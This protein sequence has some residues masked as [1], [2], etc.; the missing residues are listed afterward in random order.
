[1]YQVAVL[2]KAAH[3]PTLKVSLPCSNR[4]SP[5]QPFAVTPQAD[6]PP[7]PASAPLSL[8]SLIP[9]IHARLHAQ[10]IPYYAT[11]MSL[12]TTTLSLPKIH[13][14]ILPTP[15]SLPFAPPPPCKPRRQIPTK[16]D[17]NILPHTITD[18]AYASKMRNKQ[19]KKIKNRSV[20]CQTPCFSKQG[21]RLT[22]YFCS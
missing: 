7:N 15:P 16:M 9:N 17:R 10:F 21:A 19:K 2:A 1:M 12:Y 5:L 13:V 20:S 4:T 22:D 18:P 3:R 14:Y 8:R 11:T 6:A